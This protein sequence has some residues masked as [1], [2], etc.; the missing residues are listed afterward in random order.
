MPS[1][2]PDLP[3][4]RE[5]LFRLAEAGRLS[6]EALERALRL[7]GHL[8]DRAAW[9]TF[10][11]RMLL[12]LGLAFLLTGIFFFFAYNWA[13]MHRFVKF[14]LIEAGIAGAVA[15]AWVK[16]LDRLAGQAA[17]FVAAGMVGAFLAVF[18]QVYPTGTDVYELFL[19]WA[20]LITVWV[21]AGRSP[22]LWLLWLALVN[23][24]IVAYWTEVYDPFLRRPAALTLLLFALDG[25]ATAAWE[26]GAARGKAWM[27][28]RWL[29]GL[30]A[31]AAL[32]CL[33]IPV[34]EV[35]SRHFRFGGDPWRVAAPLVYAAAVA[36]GLWFYRTKRRDLFLLAALLVSL[37]VVVTTALGEVWGV[38][39][40]MALFLGLIVLAQSAAAAAWLRKVA[41]EGKP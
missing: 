23:A 16:G 2:A 29:P 3:A 10:A 8:P 32:V 18:G 30:T 35:V 11:D 20:A 38:E 25:G 19:T 17:L 40:W 9:R 24:T 31:T 36:F 6:P 12:L 34:L 26:A 5:R 33:V 7:A 14:A 15:T 39:D 41:R 27:R 28:G 37:I 13:S 1:D 4:T 21:A 22:A